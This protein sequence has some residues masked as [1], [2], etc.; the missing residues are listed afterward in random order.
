M[1]NLEV[2][3]QI[4][5]LYQSWQGGGEQQPYT[6]CGITN[7]SASCV[8]TTRHYVALTTAEYQPSGH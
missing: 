2:F 8:Q 6:M 1:F 7:V 3:S 4:G 5:I